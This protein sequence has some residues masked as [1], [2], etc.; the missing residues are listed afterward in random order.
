MFSVVPGSNEICLY[1]N[2]DHKQLPKVLKN[3][4]EIQPL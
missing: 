2:I 1:K 4:S 3:N